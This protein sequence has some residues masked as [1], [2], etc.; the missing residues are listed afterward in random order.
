MDCLKN[1][2]TK[3]PETSSGWGLYFSFDVA[4]HSQAK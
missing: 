4:T 2:P 1:D 3:D